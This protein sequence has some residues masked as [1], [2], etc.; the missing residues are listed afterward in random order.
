VWRECL[1]P[2]FSGNVFS[3]SLFMLILV[4]GLLYVLFLLFLNPMY[5][6]FLCVSLTNLELLVDQ[7][8]LEFRDL[9]ASASSAGVCM[10]LL[11]LDSSGCYPER[12]I[13]CCQKPFLHLRK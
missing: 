12:N 1:V 13:G 11:S 4:V 6:G 9:P 8:A 2:S 3:F 7:A 5:T 10:S